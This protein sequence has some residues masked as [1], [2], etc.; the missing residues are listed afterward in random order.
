MSS[1]ETD[2]FQST[3][4]FSPDFSVFHPDADTG[5]CSVDVYLLEHV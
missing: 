4:L 3:T 5:F 1:S 2:I